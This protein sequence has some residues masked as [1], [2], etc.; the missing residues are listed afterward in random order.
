[1]I[2]HIAQ[3]T[4]ITDKK[5]S[6][7]FQV[8]MFH[9]PTF[10]CLHTDHPLASSFGLTFVLPLVIGLLGGTVFVITCLIAAI[11]I[12]LVCKYRGTL[13]KMQPLQLLYTLMHI[14]C[15]RRDF[16]KNVSWIYDNVQTKCAHGPRDRFLSAL[17]TYCR[18]IWNNPIQFNI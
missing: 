3:L 2:E 9:L 17:V 5:F 4:A 12:V 14:F 7:L 6:L 18:Y 8:F 13:R 10:F 11:T 1:M 16:V 15:V